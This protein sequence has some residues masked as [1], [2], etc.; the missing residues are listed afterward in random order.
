MKKVVEVKEV[1]PEVPVEDAAEDEAD[2]IAE[3]KKAV[4][5][6][7][8][9]PSKHILPPDQTERIKV[10]NPHAPGSFNALN[11]SLEDGDYVTAKAYAKQFVRYQKKLMFR[12]REITKMVGEA[13]IEEGVIEDEDWDG[14]E[15]YLNMQFAKSRDESPSP[16]KVTHEDA[17]QQVSADSKGRADIYY[18]FS[19]DCS[20]CRKMAPDVERLWR[21]VKKDKNVRM[22][23]L[24]MGTH[25]QDWIRDYRDYTGMS[26]P[27]YEGSKLA[28]HFNIKFAKE[29]ITQI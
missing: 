10:K 24:T 11:E 13:L 3:I 29:L 23:G 21:V 28:E 18:F 12:V 9:D 20:W 14:V 6:I 26:L 7:P 27:I 19:L 25:M 4:D 15:Q 22:V 5:T 8:N 2:P 16:M 17:M 1:E